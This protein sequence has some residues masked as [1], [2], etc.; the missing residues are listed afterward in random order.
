MSV[1]TISI[2]YIY[3]TII[4]ISN[5]FLKAILTCFYDLDELDRT[6]AN[7]CNYHI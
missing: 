4:T 2:N 3:R 5:L 6:T 1:I 7:V